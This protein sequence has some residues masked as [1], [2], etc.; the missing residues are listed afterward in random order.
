MPEVRTGRQANAAGHGEAKREAEK[1]P[2]KETEKEAEREAE[3][4]RAAAI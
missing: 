1:E 4:G 3:G 2:E